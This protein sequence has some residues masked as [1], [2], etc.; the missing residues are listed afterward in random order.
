MIR[1]AFFQKVKHTE[2][3]TGFFVKII[4]LSGSG[5][6]ITKREKF[7]SGNIRRR[8]IK[9]AVFIP[10]AQKTE[11]PGIF[12][13]ETGGNRNRP[14][15]LQKGSL[16]SGIKTAAWKIRLFADDSWQLSDLLFFR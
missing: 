3:R 15:L 4:R 9:Y 7:F 14:V 11:N 2:I 13:S 5:M 10:I 6:K 16:F 1:L 8:I 12:P